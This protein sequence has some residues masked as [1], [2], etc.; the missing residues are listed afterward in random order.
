MQNASALEKLAAAHQRV[1]LAPHSQGICVA[2][3][4]PTAMLCVCGMCK[5]SMVA[6][7]GVRHVG[8]CEG[9]L[10]G[11]YSGASTGYFHVTDIGSTSI[12]SRGL[13]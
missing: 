2:S 10:R 8:R 11:S 7:F 9:A 12:S 1:L 3:I 13:R 5:V 6:N 4:M